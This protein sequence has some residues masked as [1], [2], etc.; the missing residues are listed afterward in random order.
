MLWPL[1]FL[2]LFLAFGGIYGGILMLMDPSGESLQVA[3]TLDLLPVSDFILPGLFLLLVM[4]AFPIF[5]AYGLVAR[6][7]WPWLDS[8]FRWSKH[9][10]AWTGTMILVAILAL[11]LI[12]EG[13][14][15]GWFPIT[16]G[17]AVTGILILIVALLPGVRNFYRQ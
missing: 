13:A 14:L 10:W 4:G 6:P 3:E 17:T 7:D 11:W 2:L 9:H 1:I 12:Y 5:L 15:I 16:Y 8:L